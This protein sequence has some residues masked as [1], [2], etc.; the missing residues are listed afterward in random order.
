MRCRQ[1]A[2]VHRALRK[3]LPTLAAGGAGKN[4]Y[5]PKWETVDFDTPIDLEKSD[6][7]QAKAAPVKTTRAASTSAATPHNNAP[8]QAKEEVSLNLK[9]VAEANCLLTTGKPCE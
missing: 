8:T 9:E 5:H 4:K 1:I 3:R 6:C 2:K 7:I